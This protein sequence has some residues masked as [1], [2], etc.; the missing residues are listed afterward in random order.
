MK[1][2]DAH[3]CIRMGQIFDE[4]RKRVVVHFMDNV[5]GGQ[6]RPGQTLLLFHY[7]TS[8]V[9]HCALGLEFSLTRQLA[10]CVNPTA[11]LVS[12][13][14]FRQ[15][16]F[17]GHDSRP[18]LLSALLSLRHCAFA[19]KVF[20]HKN[21]DQSFQHSCGNSLGRICPKNA[22]LLHILSVIHSQ[23]EAQATR[24]YPIAILYRSPM[25][26]SATNK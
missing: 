3:L 26:A 23:P 10:T 24:I 9:T 2:P 20:S 1:R 22:V 21:E 13:I 25:F 11:C 16:T 15:T 17:P 12:S 5:A 8:F 7:Y 19:L 4:A 18:M 14:W 6:R